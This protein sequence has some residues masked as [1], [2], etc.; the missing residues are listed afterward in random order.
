MTQQREPHPNAEVIIAWALG[1]PVQFRTAGKGD[2]IDWD[3]GHNVFP[4]QDR[5][6]DFAGRLE[7]QIK[8][9]ATP[10][11]ELGYEIGDKFLA[12]REDER[13]NMIAELMYDDNSR[14]PLFKVLVSFGEQNVLGKETYISLDNVKKI[15]AE[16]FK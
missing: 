3:P 5:D 11:Q 2:W 10:C 7:W 8:P 12:C 4:H 15:D 6:L 13:F 9:E 1:K 16:I 14:I